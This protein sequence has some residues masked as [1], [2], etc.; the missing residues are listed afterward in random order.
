VHSVCFNSDLLFVRYPAITWWE[1]Q[2][3][4]C[5]RCCVIMHI[6]IIESEREEPMENDRPLIIWVL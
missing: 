4:E 6:M 2:I 1:S 3:W 5:M